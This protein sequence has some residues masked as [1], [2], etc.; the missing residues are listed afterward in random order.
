MPARAQRAIQL[1]AEALEPTVR[2]FPVD[3][4]TLRSP[5]DVRSWL[6]RTETALLEAVK[7]GPVLI[8]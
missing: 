3:R 4:A 5:E 1:A 8:N 7:T 2:S 6:A